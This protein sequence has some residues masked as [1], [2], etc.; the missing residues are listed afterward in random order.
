MVVG[1][2]VVRSAG[3][4]RAT[5]GSLADHWRLRVDRSIRISCSR[6]LPTSSDRDGAQDAAC[7]VYEN[8]R[9][10]GS[11]ARTSPRQFGEAWSVMLRFEFAGLVLAAGVFAAAAQD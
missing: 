9:A 6:S 2:V 7:R 5:F 4:C 1:P 11:R 10:A 3:A 8:M